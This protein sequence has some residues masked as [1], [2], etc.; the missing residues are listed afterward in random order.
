MFCVLILSNAV[1]SEVEQCQS[2]L[3]HVREEVH[4]KQGEL[5]VKRNKLAD[6]VVETKV[7]RVRKQILQDQMHTLT[8]NKGKITLEFVS[9]INLLAAA[10]IQ[11]PY[12]HY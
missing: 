9:T 7:L 6:Q 3:Q 11:G 2:E 8:Q 1:G 4:T 12:F 5:A 10:T